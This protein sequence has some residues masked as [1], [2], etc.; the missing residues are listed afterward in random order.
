MSGRPQISHDP[1]PLI[2]LAA[3]LLRRL[4]RSTLTVHWRRRQLAATIPR[5]GPCASKMYLMC[6]RPTMMPASR[7]SSLQMRSD[8]CKALPSTLFFSGFLSGTGSKPKLLFFPNPSASSPSSASKTWMWFA[9]SL[10]RKRRA[11][12]SLPNGLECPCRCVAAA[13]LA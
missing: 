13:L 5:P 10:S 1:S 8:L 7:L 6:S 2:A 4:R 11:P 12:A 9:R 3:L